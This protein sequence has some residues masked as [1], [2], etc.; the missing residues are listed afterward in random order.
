MSTRTGSSLFM[1][2]L[3]YMVISYIWGEQD[4]FTERDESIV[5]WEHQYQREPV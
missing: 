5:Y 4:H 2:V 3:I 1:Y